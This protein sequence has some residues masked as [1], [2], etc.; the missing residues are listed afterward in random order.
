MKKLIGVILFLSFGMIYAQKI[1]FAY[2][3]KEI[4]IKNKPKAADS[5]LNIDEYLNQQFYNARYYLLVSDMD[6][7]K[8]LFTLINTIGE[9]EEIPLA[10]IS[11]NYY[12]SKIEGLRNNHKMALKLLYDA[13][14]LAISSRNYRF[15]NYIQLGLIEIFRKEANYSGA[16]ELLERLKGHIFNPP[17][18]TFGL[19]EYYNRYAAIYNEVKDDNTANRDSSIAFSNK[20]I[21]LCLKISAKNRLALSY[22]EIGYSYENL[23]KYDKALEFYKKAAEVYKLINLDRNYLN[24]IN[25]MAR[26]YKKQNKFNES[27]KLIEKILPELDKFNWTQMSA[28]LY[29]LKAENHEM[30]KQY[31][32]AV[33]FY[34]KS[35]EYE[36]NRLTETFDFDITREQ[37]KITIEQLN[38]E[39]LTKNKKIK[40]QTNWIIGLL[41]LIAVYVIILTIFARMLWR[42][43]T[44]K[45]ERT[46]QE[47]E[48]LNIISRQREEIKNK[49]LTIKELEERYELIRKMIE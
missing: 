32:S 30:L 15:Q 20:A 48:Y 19:I 7:A 21:K 5:T 6:S 38:E 8:T 2:P 23:Y 39:V 28:T 27:I 16:F 22:N 3:S 18:D 40:K 9:E 41:I 26:I 14:S 49:N 17:I 45:K 44:L 34:K 4:Q 37:N 42:N 36:I 47:K 10:I 46:N 12:L 11:S 25:N 35:F 29:R 31:D 24:T 33:F 43:R 13:N 1:P